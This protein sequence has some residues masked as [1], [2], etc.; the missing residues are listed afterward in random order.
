M[1]PLLKRLTEQL[2][3]KWR[4]RD[5]A[6]DMAKQILWNRWH[7]KKWTTEL[8]PSWMARSNMSAW[9]RAI[10]RQVKYRWWS[11]YDYEYNAK[12]NWAVKRK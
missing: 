12:T 7:M 2:I 4:T 5:D 9:D 8:T 11:R 1:N 10:D 6:E 3:E